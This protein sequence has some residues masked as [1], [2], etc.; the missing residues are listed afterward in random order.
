[1]TSVIS[2]F[3][4]PSLPPPPA[5]C[6]DLSMAALPAESSTIACGRT[7]LLTGCPP[8]PTADTTVVPNPLPAAALLLCPPPLKQPVELPNAEPE[9]IETSSPSP[10]PIA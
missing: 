9:P 6:R 7:I 5:L 2:L 10:L 4:P 1:M 8:I 3:P